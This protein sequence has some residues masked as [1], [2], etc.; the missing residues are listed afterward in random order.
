MPLLIPPATSRLLLTIDPKSTLA[1]LNLANLYKS[2]GKLK[3]AVKYYNKVLEIRPENLAAHSALSDLL[4][5]QK[6]IPEALEHYYYILKLLI[7]AW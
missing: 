2:Q 1:M 7:K 5:Q 6:N 3:E 4:V